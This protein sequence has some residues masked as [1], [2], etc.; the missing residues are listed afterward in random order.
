MANYTPDPRYGRSIDEEAIA[1]HVVEGDARLQRY[2]GFD[3]NPSVL[4]DIDD[5]SDG[6]TAFTCSDEDWSALIGENFVPMTLTAK[7]F[8]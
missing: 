3:I 1:R 4:Y 7:T 6:A 5:V 8:V 2:D